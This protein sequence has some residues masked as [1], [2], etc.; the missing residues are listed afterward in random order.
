MISSNYST[1]SFPFEELVSPSFEI[2]ES[3]ELA[4][5]IGFLNTWYT[6]RRY[7]EMTRRNPVEAI[8]AELTAAWGDPARERVVT[9]P[10][11]MRVGRLRSSSCGEAVD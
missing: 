5:L 10:L 11:H 7:L 4:R 6:S 1:L 9:W 8:R 2:V 3:W